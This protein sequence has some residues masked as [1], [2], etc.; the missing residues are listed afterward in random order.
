MGLFD[1]MKCYPRL[2]R[3]PESHT[4]TIGDRKAIQMLEQGMEPIGAM[5]IDPETGRRATVDIYGRVQW[6]E[7]DGAGALVCPVE[8]LVR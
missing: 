8:R 1:C 2:C 5:L 3:C 6:W 7:V 4:E